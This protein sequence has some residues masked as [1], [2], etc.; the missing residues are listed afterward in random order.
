MNKRI[1]EQ[2]RKNYLTKHSVHG[3]CS[4]C[5]F[6]DQFFMNLLSVNKE[7]RKKIESISCYDHGDSSCAFHAKVYNKIFGFEFP[8]DKNGS[9]HRIDCDYYIRKHIDVLHSIEGCGR[10]LKI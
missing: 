9:H 4:E 10:C 7:V 2:A 8:L 3:G 5:L 1:F 6:S